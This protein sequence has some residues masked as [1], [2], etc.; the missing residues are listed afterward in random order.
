MPAETFH[1]RQSQLTPTFVKA[2]VFTGPMELEKNN[3]LSQSYSLPLINPIANLEK[4]NP[5][6]RSFIR[7]ENPLSITDSTSASSVNS[8]SPLLIDPRLLNESDPLPIVRPS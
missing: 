3:S 7:S 6:V 5:S 1:S 2:I 4:R 8:N